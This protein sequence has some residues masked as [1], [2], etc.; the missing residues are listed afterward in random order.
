MK[1][2]CLETSVSEYKTKKSYLVL[3]TWQYRDDL[4]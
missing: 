3:V 2:F 4:M 1:N